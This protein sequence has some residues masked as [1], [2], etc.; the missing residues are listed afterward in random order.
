[1][2]HTLFKNDFQRLSEVRSLFTKALLVSLIPQRKL[3][4]KR[5]VV[6]VVKN[7]SFVYRVLARRY[8]SIN[9]SKYRAIWQCLESLKSSDGKRDFRTEAIH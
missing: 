3:N 9:E 5:Q 8:C 6:K 7:P 4:V 1:M 2:P